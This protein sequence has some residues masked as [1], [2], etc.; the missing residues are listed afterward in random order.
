MNRA[1]FEPKGRSIATPSGQI[2]YVENG[3]GPVA[4]FV[5]GV[6]LNG[7]L[8][9]HQLA[10]L[11]GTR[12]CVALDLMAHGATKIVPTHD[13]SYD[14]QATM[15]EQFL[16]AMNIDTVDLVGND[17]GGGISQRFFRFWSGSA[18][19]VRMAPAPFDEE[20]WRHARRRTLPPP[21]WVWS[22][23][24]RSDPWS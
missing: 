6:L 4:L 2:S 8:W 16:D 9:R 19:D 3:K 10:D 18:G 7:Y 14:A 23:H 13:V 21:G 20:G 24:G 15:L 17:G 5:H 12:R 22:R 1:A 11:S